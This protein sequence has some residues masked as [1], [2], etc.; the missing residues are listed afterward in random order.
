MNLDKNQNIAIQAAVEAGYKI[1]EIYNSFNGEVVSK[2]DNSPLTIA[3]KESNEIIKNFLLQTEI[4]IIS[5]EIKNADFSE[6]KNWNLCWIVD[7]LDGT[8]EFIKRNGQFTVN[9]ALVENGKPVFGVI[10]VPVTKELYV[11]FV[12]EGKSLFYK[13][14]DDKFSIDDFINNSSELK[15]IKANK[16]INVVCSNSH[17]NEE[18]QVYIDSLKQQ[19]EVVNSVNAGSSLKFCLVASGKAQV[20]PRLAPTMEWDT[21]AGQAICNAVGVKVISQETN[22]EL[23][24]NKENL[25]NPSFIVSI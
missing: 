24:Y 9:I 6:R 4:P 18:T 12:N 22:E 15:P 17:L 7:P 14:I 21:A 1:V 5:E 3:D 19:F 2:D 16:T 11:G 10:Y 25:L 13:V 8:K 23:L 20:Y